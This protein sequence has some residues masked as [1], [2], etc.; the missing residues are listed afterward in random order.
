MDFRIM[1]S[2]IKGLSQSGCWGCFDE[3]NRI[4]LEVLSVVAQQVGSVFE[5][6]KADKKTFQF[7]D[8]H[9]I[10]LDKEVGYFITMNPG[11]AGRQE[12]PENLKSL[13]RGVTMMC[14]P[15]ARRAPPPS[16]SIRIHITSAHAHTSA[17]CCCCCPLRGDDSSALAELPM[18]E[19]PWRRGR[20]NIFHF[21]GTERS[22]HTMLLHA[23]T[24][25]PCLMTSL[26]GCVC[27][28][29]YLTAR[30]S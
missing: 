21:Q 5:S 1:G 24:P 19:R 28:A 15:L 23:M 29:G 17:F 4:D 18:A 3:F 7:T 8:G 20:H 30:S 14:A 2:I 26:A 27:R 6:I 25:P 11:Y 13:F 22:T 12:L 16:T 9:V 10:N